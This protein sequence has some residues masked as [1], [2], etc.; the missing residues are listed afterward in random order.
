MANSALAM[1]AMDD[2]RALSS[3]SFALKN[4]IKRGKHDGQDMVTHAKRKN[5]GARSVIRGGCD[6]CITLSNFNLYHHRFVISYFR[7]HGSCKKRRRHISKHW[8]GVLC[9]CTEK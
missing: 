7:D 3:K 6:K 1:E 9:F 4:A 5:I 8:L 2:A